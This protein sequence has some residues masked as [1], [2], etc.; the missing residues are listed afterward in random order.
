MSLNATSSI[1]DYPTIVNTFIGSSLSILGSVLVALLY[2]RNQNKLENIKKITEFINNKYIEDGLDPLSVAVSE[3]GISIGF[4]ILDV[5]KWATRCF[6]NARNESLFDSEIE[7]I[8]NRTNII[9]LKN[10]ELKLASKYYPNIVSFGS[11]L[12]NSIRKTLQMFSTYSMELTDLNSIKEKIMK[13][14][15]ETVRSLGDMALLFDMLQRYIVSRLEYLKEYLLRQKLEDI[16]A[17]F[18][19][20]QNEEFKVFQTELKEYISFLDRFVNA[21]MNVSTPE[22]REEASLSLSK[23]VIENIDHDPLKKW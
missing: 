13:D 14:P 18:I 11:S 12:Q 22:E 10:R 9:D 23:L 2:I 7:K 19:I 5:R 8:S 17:I 3:Y 15:K 4:L 20:D 21:F 16:N 6:I 1:I